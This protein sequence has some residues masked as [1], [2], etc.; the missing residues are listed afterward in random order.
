MPSYPGKGL[1]FLLTLL[2]ALL[3]AIYSFWAAAGQFVSPKRL[4]IQDYQLSWL[5]QPDTHGLSVSGQLCNH[6]LTPCLFISANPNLKPAMR[7]ASLREQLMSR[8]VTL[9]PYGQ[10]QGILILLHGRTGRKEN[11]L[12][13]AE[14]FAALGFKCVLID[15]PGHG[16]SPITQTGFATAEIE[17]QLLSNLLTEARQFFAEPTSPAFLWGISMGGAFAVHSAAQAPNLWRGL[18]VVSSFDNLSSVIADHFNWLPQPL[19]QPMSQWFIELIDNRHAI[20]LD[21]AQPEKWAHNVT[22]PTFI[23]HGDQDSVIGISHGKQLFAAIQNHKKTW[24]E[25][26]GADHDNILITDYPLYAAMGE[27]LIAQTQ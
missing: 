24:L 25:V 14:R 5:N 17:Q 13:A 21:Q 27:W 2:L 20:R 23:A 4:P 16:D 19:A 6:G 22:I 7:G 10:S 1:Y 8:G 3:I 12:A 9:K 26:A 15:L 11:L 18:M